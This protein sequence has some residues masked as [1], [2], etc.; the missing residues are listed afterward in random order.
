VRSDAILE[1]RERARVCVAWTAIK[2][3]LESGALQLSLFDQRDIA[4]ITAPKFPGERL[5]V[6][7]NAEL[8]TERAASARIYLAATERE[9]ARVKTA[10]GRKRDPI[11]GATEIALRGGRSAE[12]PQDAQALRPRYH[13]CSLSFRRKTAEV[14][15]EAATDGL[16]VVRMDLAAE[17]LGDA[18]TV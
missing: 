15:A 16:Y 18:E 13:R 7:R 9:L 8:A 11:R 4:S 17:V 2:A 1:G 12:R 14:A 3:L 5:I 10:V 6:C